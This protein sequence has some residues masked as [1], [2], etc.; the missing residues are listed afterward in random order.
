M[1]I[2]TR[3][4][5]L[6]EPLSPQEE[7]AF[8]E[9]QEDWLAHYMYVPLVL[10]VIFQLY[11]IGY[12]L[13]YT[14]FTL[15]TVPSRVY[16][17]LYLIALAASAGV[18]AAFRF[19]RRSGRVGDVLRLQNIYVIVVVLWGAAVSAY[20]QRVSK[21]IYV[22]LLVIFTVAVAGR[23]R[24]R[25]AIPLFLA[26]E[27]ALLFGMDLVVEGQDWSEL[28]SRYI[29]SFFAVCL[30]AF[31]SCQRYYSARR[32]FANRSIIRQQHREIL[33]QSRKLDFMAHHDSMTGLP[34][35][36]CLSAYVKELLERGEDGTA[37][38]M[39]DIDDFKEY[40]DH[41]GHVAGDDC[42]VRVS[43]A[44]QLCLPDGMIFRYGG[45]EFLGVVPGLTRERAEELGDILRRSVEGLK[46]PMP[47]EDGPVTVSVGLAMGAVSDEDGWKSLLRQADRALYRA[48]EDGKNRLSVY[49]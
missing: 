31:L 16:A 14:D 48:K 28:Y 47:H 23:L 8:R 18:L 26:G 4:K 22:F 42:L 25:L 27:L 24:P 13:W 40:N 7:R 20:D 12:A 35:R 15:S 34:N 32:D 5:Q 30:M 41:L 29:N 38:Y 11:N 19:A 49:C 9:S 43:Q 39:I 3:L 44:M 2:W 33:E 10:M 21:N 6:N 46:I 37:V 45:E 17:V 36:R 1:G